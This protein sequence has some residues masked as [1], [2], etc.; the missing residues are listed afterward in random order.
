MKMHRRLAKG[1]LQRHVMYM[2]EVRVQAWGQTGLF[3]LHSSKHQAMSLASQVKR[4][5]P[6]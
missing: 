4:S 3:A 2:Q 6:T 5:K 1:I